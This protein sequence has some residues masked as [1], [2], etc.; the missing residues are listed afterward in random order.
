MDRSGAIQ[1]LPVLHAVALRLRGIGLDDE[2]I[3]IAL[4]IDIDQVPVLVQLAERKLERLMN[5]P[6]GAV[7]AQS[8]QH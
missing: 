8:R 4:D 6:D 2:V 5:D 3:A 1:Q 7:L